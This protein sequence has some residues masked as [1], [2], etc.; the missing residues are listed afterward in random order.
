[1]VIRIDIC[2]SMEFYNLKNSKHLQIVQSCFKRDL[3]EADAIA[4]LLPTAKAVGYAATAPTGLASLSAADVAGNDGSH[5]GRHYGCGCRG[6][7]ARGREQGCA[8]AVADV[9]DFV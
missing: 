8:G 9:G 4:R 7:R 2:H 5:A 1:M 6:E 3:Y